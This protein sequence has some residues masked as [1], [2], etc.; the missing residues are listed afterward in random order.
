MSVGDKPASRTGDCYQAGHYGILDV[1]ISEKLMNAE[2]AGAI[3][4]SRI[5][6]AIEEPDMGSANGRKQEA[7]D[8]FSVQ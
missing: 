2:I 1:Q 8:R 3:D 4:F 7:Y 5:V 6:N